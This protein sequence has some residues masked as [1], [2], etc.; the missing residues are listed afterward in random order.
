MVKG[1][2][3]RKG[4]RRQHHTHRQLCQ[5]INGLAR[6]AGSEEFRFL[7]DLACA[8]HSNFYEVWM[9]AEMIDNSLGQVAELLAKL[10]SVP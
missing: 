4:W 1:I 5:V 2:A 10:K 6:E 7:F 3:E 8:L 9:P